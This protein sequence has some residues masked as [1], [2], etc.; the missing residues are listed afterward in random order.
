MN[1]VTAKEKYL[2]D[3]AIQMK[4]EFGYSSVMQVPRIKKVVVNVGT[5]KMLKD[6]DRVEEVVSSCRRLPGKN[7]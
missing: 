6:T 2:K 4:K 5:G 3:A 7:R 1:T